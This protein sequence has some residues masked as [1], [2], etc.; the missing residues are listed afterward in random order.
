VD[1]NDIRGVIAAKTARV[2]YEKQTIMISDAAKLGLLYEISPGC[3][4][5]EGISKRHIRINKK[6]EY[7][8]NLRENELSQRKQ[9]DNDTIS[10]QSRVE[11]SREEKNKS[12]S[13]AFAPPSLTEVSAYCKERG[14]KVDPQKWMDHYSSNGWRVG[15]NPMRDWRAAVRTWERSEFGVKQKSNKY[16]PQSYTKADAEE[17]MR[18]IFSKEIPCN[19]MFL[20]KP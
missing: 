16:G 14:N 7:D 1:L 2:S 12:K 3:Y 6:R 4:T 8:R 10:T 18:E 13:V 19:S 15:R 11:K 17:Q 20:P 9:Y 5:S